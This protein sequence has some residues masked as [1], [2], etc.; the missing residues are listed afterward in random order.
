MINEGKNVRITGLL[1]IPGTVPPIVSCFLW[2]P[3]LLS[4][5]YL[6]LMAAQR[7]RILGAALTALCMGYACAGIGI[8]LYKE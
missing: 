7:S 2:G 4:P 3:S 8:S 1:F 5:D 6:S